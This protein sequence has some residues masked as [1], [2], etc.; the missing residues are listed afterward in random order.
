MK[1]HY[2]CSMV[3]KLEHNYHRVGRLYKYGWPRHC[4]YVI[5]CTLQKAKNTYGLKL[6]N[7]HSC[8]LGQIP[9][10]CI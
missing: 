10:D 7:F 9:I 6:S 5:Q 3:S 2:Y 4:I 8:N 1:R